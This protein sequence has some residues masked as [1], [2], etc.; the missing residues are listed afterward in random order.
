MAQQVPIE[1]RINALESRLL[2]LEKAL[3]VSDGKILLTTGVAKISITNHDIVV[4]AAGNIQIKASGEIVL[5]GSRIRE[6]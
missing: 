3:Q 4:E 2:K 5:K 6:N 1:E